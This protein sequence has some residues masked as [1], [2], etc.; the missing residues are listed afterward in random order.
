MN[1]PARHLGVGLGYR[2]ELA[3]ELER[4]LTEVDFIEFI[5]DNCFQAALL[6]Q[7]E[8]LAR[9]LPMVCH[10]VGLSLGSAE[11]L[12]EAYISKL[13]IVLK[14]I[15]P[16]WLSDHLA[17]TRVQGIDLGHL[18]PVFFT[19]ETVKIISGKIAA[20]QQRFGLPLLLEN[21]TYHFTLPR[22]SLTE[23]E[24][25]R[26]IVEASDCGI[27]LDLNNLY[28]NARNNKYDP[29]EFLR[30]IPLERVAQIHIAGATVREG[31]LIDSHGHP[32]GEEVFKYL[33]YVCQ[34]SPVSAI[35]L[36]RDKNMPSF[37]E[38]AQ[39]MRRARAILC[40]VRA[41]DGRC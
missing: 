1:I 14:R 32:V 19:E 2:A 10:C 36:E 37:E 28:I 5:G 16:L 9:R 39:E 25:L 26:R 29:Y 30:S 7:I 31:L 20:L 17:I 21:I 8:R 38:L 35:L 15:R 13:E 11:P 22:A 24:L 18:A 41:I 12:D 34:R 40:A 4:N 3:D 6:T 23:W 33:E 27:L